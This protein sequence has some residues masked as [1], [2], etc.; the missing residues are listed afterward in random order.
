MLVLKILEIITGAI[1][2][3][4]GFLIYFRGKYNLANDYM[5]RL[6]KGEVTPLYAKSIGL[7]Y[8][9]GGLALI[10]FGAFA[11]MMNDLFTFIQLFV[12]LISI[13][14]LILTNPKR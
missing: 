1:L 7:I 9:F 3:I 14:L 4:F 12:I 8:F 13:V 10:I 2:L 6:N 5:D 11:F